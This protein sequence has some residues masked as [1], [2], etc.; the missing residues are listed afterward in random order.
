[1]TMTNVPLLARMTGRDRHEPHRVATPLELF[2]DL[3]FVVAVASS[4]AQ[5]HH[6]LSAGHAEAVIGFVMAFLATWWA[7]MGFTW[8]SS[9][10]DNDDA[11]YRLLAFTIMAGALIFAA[12]VPDLFDDGQSKLA[13]LGYAVMRLAQV[14]LWLR[15]ARDH[16]EGR[17]TALAY[18]IG[19]ALAQV[20]WILRLLV[21]DPTWLI[22]T[23]VIGFL[24]E[25]SVPAIAELRF[26]NS[27]FHPHHI[28][29]RYSLFTI[30]VLGEVVLSSVTAVQGLL[31][32]EQSHALAAG[33]EGGVAR[34]EAV[35]VGSGD[36][37]LM[38]L[39][40]LLI[41]FSLWWLYFKRGWADLFESGGGWAFF[42]A[43]AH[44]LVFGSV[45]A[46]GAG[47]AAG[48]DVV[49]GV[50][51]AS[52]RFVAL[53]MAIPLSIYSLVLAGMHALE[54]RNPSSA[55]MASGVSALLLGAALAGWS[56]PWTVFAFG[57]VLTGAVVQHVVSS[58]R[59][60][61]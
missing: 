37:M 45:A 58:Q 25:I 4:A 27:P 11:V 13:V 46:T 15:V 33:G 32:N 48:V 30:I 52:P 3:I 36:L 18:A 43:Y 31:A 19:I 22:V 1:M 35:T 2:F 38:M 21:E 57:L 40:G 16:T 10:Y 54:Q 7:W 12:S 59:Q 29:E 42:A 24:L 26:G 55:L 20:Y 51:A 50:A 44:V 6:G 28:A 49:Q 8:F 56:M 39:G 41:V 60:A 9:A 5:L 61:H 53:A 14:V 47:L 23:F 34:H 17:R